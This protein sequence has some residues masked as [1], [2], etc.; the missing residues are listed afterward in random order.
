M[1]VFISVE[2]AR[3]AILETL[4]AQPDVQVDL[5]ASMHQTL[6]NDIISRESI[7]PFNNSGMDGYA[8]VSQ[9]FSTLPVTLRVVDEIPAGAVS[10]VC[11]EPGT[12]AKIM[13][14]A[15]VPAGADSVVPVEW[16]VD[17]SSEHVS[18][19]KAPAAGSNIRKS[20]QDVQEGEIVITKG[21]TVTPPVIGMLA[22]L[23]YAKVGVKVPPTVAVIATGD[24][25][26]SPSELLTPGKIRNSSGYAL[27][28]QVLDCGGQ[29][30]PP[31][32]A[33]DNKESIRKTVEHALSADVL[34]FAGGVSVGRL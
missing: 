22:T 23:G 25:L 30:L 21:K 33:R 14:G 15:P 2:K 10:D 27:R 29:V 26:I 9:D 20:G 34:V 17:S 12:C 11:V 1:Q 32:L 28:S 18:F 13:T 7:P 5:D 4:S 3:S 24:E 6:A 8:V 31:L 16:V 19:A